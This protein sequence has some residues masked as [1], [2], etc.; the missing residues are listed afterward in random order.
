MTGDIVRVRVRIR[1][2]NN[3]KNEINFYKEATIIQEAYLS[4][5]IQ[6]LERCMLQRDIF[7]GCDVE[8]SNNVST[9]NSLVDI[10]VLTF[11]GTIHRGVRGLIRRVN[12]Y[13]GCKC[14]KDE[15]ENSFKRL[16]KLVRI[17]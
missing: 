12:P 14:N 9:Y 8:S 6:F 15:Y 7:A 1:N 5:A 2:E 4:F 13:T 3:N 11:Q 17:R 10:D 16:S